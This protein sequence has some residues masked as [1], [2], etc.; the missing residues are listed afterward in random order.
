VTEQGHDAVT[1]R[2]AEALFDL[3][4][5]KD[6]LD[7]VERDVER[8]GRELA[9]PGVAAYLF[10]T[11]VRIAERRAKLD[12]LLGAMHRL[13]SNFVSLLFDKRREEVLR[14]LA[15]AFH[16]RRLVLD[17]KAEGV[18]ESAGRLSDDDVARLAGA[19]SKRLDK[20][21]T[22]EN[23]VTPDLISGVRVTADNRMID[24]SARGRLDRLRR[25][26]LAAPLPSA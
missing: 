12:P 23:R 25:A 9:R 24:Y 10:D 16:Q 21:V 8:L 26:M 19:L 1:R 22:L 15:G 6:V 5:K 17:R 20:T 4:R 2:Y 18:V 3:A 7:E 11:R 14:G 13:T